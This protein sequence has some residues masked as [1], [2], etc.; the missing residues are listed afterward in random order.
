MR[1]THDVAPG[2][3]PIAAA[4][5]VGISL[6]CLAMNTASK[7]KGRLLA[8]ATVL[9]A[10]TVRSAAVNTTSCAQDAVDMFPLS[11]GRLASLVKNASSDRAVMDDGWIAL[12]ALGMDITAFDTQANLTTRAFDGRG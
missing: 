1:A 6:L 4:A 11:H 9:T 8:L 12:T 5:A 10:S 3:A 2:D 7:N